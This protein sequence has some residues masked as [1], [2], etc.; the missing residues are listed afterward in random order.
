MTAESLSLDKPLAIFRYRPVRFLWLARITTALA[1]QMQAVAVGWQVYELTS[2]PLH[3]GFVGLMMFIPAVLLLL[4]V[5]PIVDR[6]N[7]KLIISLAQIVMAAAVGFLAVMTAAGL[8]TTV[9]ILGAVFVLGAARSFEATAMQTMPPSIVPPVVLPQVIA[10][11]SSAYQVATIVGPGI[12]GLLLILGPTWVYV[13]CC[14]LFAISSAF[15]WLIR[16]THAT[17]AREPFSL[18][19]LFSGIKFVSQNPIVLGAMSLDMFAVIFAGATAL[20]PVYARDIFDVGPTGLGLM[21]T[22]PAVGAIIVSLLIVRWPLRYDVGRTMYMG[23]AMYGFAT[24]VFGISTSYP[25]ALVALAVTGGADMLSVVIRQPLI[26]LETPDAVRGRVSAVNSLFIGT[27]NQI[28][29]FR[30]GLAAHY[31]GTV[32]SVL[33]GGV[34]TLLVVLLWIKAF[35]ALYNVHTFQKRYK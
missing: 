23:V 15:V 31:F 24:I 8:I 6:F 10:G 21:R 13:T 16:M 34:G 4:V 26:Q 3:L 33:I 20:F 11:M 17:P 25:L 30:A 32:P 2:S 35:P 12:G 18:D 22:A 29:E 28:G 27:S 9:L 1:Y 7:R 5:G 19:S 14:A